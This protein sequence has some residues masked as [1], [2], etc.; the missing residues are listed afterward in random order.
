MRSFL[1]KKMM[2][3]Y[4]RKEEE[5]PIHRAMNFLLIWAKEKSNFSEKL[6]EVR[7]DPKISFFGCL[8]LKVS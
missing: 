7:N 1:R 4:S 3:E 6:E 5:T 2:K 8:E